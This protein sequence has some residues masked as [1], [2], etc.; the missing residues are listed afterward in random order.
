VD[1][2]Q[3]RRFV[4]L[5]DHL[6]F[7]RAAELLGE[8]QS[9]LSL[10]IMSLERSIGVRLF[11]RTKRSVNLTNAGREFL[12]EVRPLLEQLNVAL[13]RT[14]EAQIGRRGILSIG[15]SK[16]TLSSHFPFIVRAFRDA[17]PEVTLDVRI[18]Y[19]G[20]V[21]EDL[22]DRRVHVAFARANVKA[23][24][25]ASELLWQ[26][27]LHVLL[28]SGHL[29]AKE[30]AVQLGRLRGET[31]LTYPRSLIGESQDELIG[32]C[33]SQGFIP[34]AIHEIA[35]ADT[36]IGLVSC[37]LGVSVLARNTTPSPGTVI[38]PI[39]GRESLR[40]S[41]AA[42]WRSDESS[43][44]VAELLSIARQRGNAKSA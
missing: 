44:L 20:R 19:T 14:R 25:V 36:I 12:R 28:P 6:H 40:Q 22:H 17:Y 43:S 30:K 37:G 27:A 5:A 33:R 3:L 34:K 2:K 9:T 7:G 15:A 41:I 39:A 35:D 16:P 13:E 31:L 4:C 11:E 32:F 21:I 10:Q 23:A 42:Y 38:R 24:G 18:G 8:S 26:V 1:T 29:Q